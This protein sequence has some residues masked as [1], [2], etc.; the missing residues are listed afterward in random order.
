MRDGLPYQGSD[1]RGAFEKL[2]EINNIL[3]NMFE[4][5]SKFDNKDFHRNIMVATLHKKAFVEY[6]KRGGWNLRD[7]DSAL[8]LLDEIQDG[9]KVITI[10][11]A[12]MTQT[13]ATKTAIT[14]TYA[15]RRATIMNGTYA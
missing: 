6:V 12:V 11:K 8:E 14:R 15:A 3:P 9:I 5:G 2:F 7:E 1:H 13:R 10:S 4:G